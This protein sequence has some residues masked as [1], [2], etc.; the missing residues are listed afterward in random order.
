MKFVALLL[1]IA[2]MVVGLAGVF[3]PERLMSSARYLVTPAGLYAIA[4]LRVAVGIVLIMVAPSSRAPRTLRLFGAV[5]LLDGLMTPLFG[6]ERTRAVFEW[7]S[8]QGTALIQIVAAVVVAIGGF[9]AFAVAP[10]RRAI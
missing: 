2:V 3:A 7:E 1:A 8:T 9:L 5:E 6:L 4:A 10:V